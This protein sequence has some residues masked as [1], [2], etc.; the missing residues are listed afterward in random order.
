MRYIGVA[1]LETIFGFHA[2]SP[3]YEDAS[4]KFWGLIKPW[5][6]DFLPVCAPLHYNSE[7]LTQ[8]RSNSCENTT[9]CTVIRPERGA[10]PSNVSAQVRYRVR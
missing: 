10:W 5:R 3:E 6:S 9:Q 4:S 1:A 8:V 7:A 2:R